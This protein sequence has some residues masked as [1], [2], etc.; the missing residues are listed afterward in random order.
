MSRMSVSSNT[1]LNFAVRLVP[2]EEDGID[3]LYVKVWY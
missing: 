2:S 3:R 1:F